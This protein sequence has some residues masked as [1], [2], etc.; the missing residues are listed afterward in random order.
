MN[1]S[2]NSAL[3][4]QTIKR[5]DAISMQVDEGCNNIRQDMKITAEAFYRTAVGKIP[6]WVNGHACRNTMS[7]VFSIRRD[8]K[9]MTQEL[10]DV[11]S[12]NLTA[13][14][15]AWSS[16]TFVPM[17]ENE[18]ETLAQA[19]SMDLEGCLKDLDQVRMNVNIDSEK[20]VDDSTPSST[21]RLLSTGG[22]LL[23]GDIAG[24]IMGGLAGFSGTL[25]TITCEI[26]AGIIL[27]IV[28]LFNPVSMTAVVA[29]VII[30]SVIG[31]AWA[32]SDMEKKIKQTVIEKSVASLKTGSSSLNFERM[33][34]DE[35]EKYLDKIRER[36]SGICAE[37]KGRAASYRAAIA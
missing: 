28:S 8:A 37:I 1:T 22:S 3:I 18:V 11:I 5:A 33:V 34:D 9:A 2:E 26:T 10:M 24:A 4:E 27:G 12:D 14:A 6:Q 30:S 7:S 35:V 16:N 20:I 32:L 21:N 17:L 13:E 31:G 25:K 19:V 36:A 29:A 15:E 23:F